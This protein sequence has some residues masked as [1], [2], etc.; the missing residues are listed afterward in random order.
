M[1]NLCAQKNKKRIVIV[2]QAVNYLTISI[3]NAFAERF[4]EVALITGS[5]HAQGE[6]L[7]AKIKVTTINRWYERPARKKLFSYIAGTFSILLLLLT[8]FRKYEV[9][10]VSIPPMA[11]LLKVILPHRFSMLIWDVYPDIFKITGMREQ[12]II[13][14]SWAAL[15]K[16]V[17]RRA[18]RLFTIGERMAGLLSKYVDKEKILITPLWSIFQ[19]NEK[20]PKDK[21]PFVREHNL[22][23]KFVVQYSGNMG[24]THNVELLVIIA[25]KLKEY[26]DVVFLLIGRGPRV[27]YLRKIVAEKSIPN[28]KFLDFQTD[29][30]FPHSLSAADLGVV[31]LDDITAQGSVP[32]KS[33]NIMSFGIPS[34]YIASEDSEL[35]DYVKKYN[36]GACF[37]QNDL[38]SA[39]EFILKIY[40]DKSMWNFYSNNAEEAA[41]N[42]RRTN[43]N[44][45][46][47]YYLFSAT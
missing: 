29:D 32:S 37:S 23:G 7:N 16:I 5:I 6:E 2:N 17:F 41:K 14:R 38:N 24:L 26:H 19:G 45:I 12:H 44:K 28:C 42:F 27:P 34:L 25:E 10:F 31:I 43:A 21:N 18:Y 11:Y 1:V 13:Y 3:C 35:N 46:V 9:F 47:E 22:A 39:A 36:H 8:R 30:T 40:Q 20:A 15:N 33:Y 4:D